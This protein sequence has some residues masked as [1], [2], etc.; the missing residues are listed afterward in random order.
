L[1]LA[2]T[3]PEQF[4]EFWSVDL[5]KDYVEGELIGAR[6]CHGGGPPARLLLLSIPVFPDHVCPDLGVP[7]N[8]TGTVI[9]LLFFTPEL[10]LLTLVARDY[11]GSVE[12]FT[13]YTMT[14][15]ILFLDNGKTN[16]QLWPL[17][18]EGK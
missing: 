13:P 5:A 17:K 8:C 2:K 4:C 9:F 12:K 14:W 1:A 18:Y 15:Q 10:S 11:G 6:L 3:F 7:C 16:F